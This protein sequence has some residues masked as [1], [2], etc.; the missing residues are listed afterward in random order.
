MTH[1]PLQLPATHIGRNVNL[2]CRQAAEPRMRDALSHHLVFFFVVVR[3]RYCAVCANIACTA[4]ATA[5]CSET[6]GKAFVKKSCSRHLRLGL[7]MHDA[8][9]FLFFFGVE[10]A[11][12]I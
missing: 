12:C 2:W 1:R 5:L 8:I 4:Q 6:I 11:F 10:G 3:I 9:A 7:Q